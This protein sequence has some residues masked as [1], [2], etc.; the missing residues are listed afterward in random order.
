MPKEAMPLLGENEKFKKKAEKVLNRVLKSGNFGHNND[1]S[2]RSKYTGTTYKV[3]AMW[4]RFTDFAS[5]VPVF[6]VDAPKFFMGYL[7]GKVG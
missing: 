4:R 6:P 3:V 1:L 2:Y 5:L 7:F